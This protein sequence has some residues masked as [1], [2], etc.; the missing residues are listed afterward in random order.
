LIAL[1]WR[2]RK[3]GV[4]KLFS[5]P[6][7][8]KSSSRTTISPAQRSGSKKQPLARRAEANRNCMGRRIVNASEFSGS[9]REP[10][11]FG[12][13]RLWVAC[14]CAGDSV[15]LRSVG[16]DSLGRIGAIA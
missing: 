9:P 16:C 14:R 10:H 6:G 15:Q 4:R 8:A 7:V 3:T 1:E 5:S 11:G 2:R 13:G 12:I